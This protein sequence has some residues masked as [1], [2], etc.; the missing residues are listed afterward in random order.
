MPSLHLRSRLS[1]AV[2]TLPGV[3]ADR[4]SL[5]RGLRTAREPLRTVGFWT[6]VALPALHVP[7]LLSGL[8]TAGEVVAFAALVALNALALWAG[9]GHDPA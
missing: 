6:A 5:D 9:H 2:A 1:R 4:S 7:L 8:D 3:G